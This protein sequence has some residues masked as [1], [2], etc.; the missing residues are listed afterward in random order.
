MSVTGSDAHNSSSSRQH[1]GRKA[2]NC[3]SPNSS[4][5]HP[6]KPH[7]MR[8]VPESLGGK[9]NRVAGQERA[10]MLVGMHENGGG[11]GVSGRVSSREEEDLMPLKQLSAMRSVRQSR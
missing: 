1:S 7:L 3:T 5:H 2:S 10:S 4:R 6:P 9:G 11:V 8:S